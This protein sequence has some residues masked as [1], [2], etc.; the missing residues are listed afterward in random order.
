VV[1]EMFLHRI[2]LGVSWTGWLVVSGGASIVV[3]PECGVLCTIQ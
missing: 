1:G 2:F 3:P